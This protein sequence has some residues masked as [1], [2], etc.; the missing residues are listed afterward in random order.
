MN[1]LN[2][3]NPVHGKTITSNIKKGNKSP[4]KRTEPPLYIEEYSEYLKNRN[5]SIST[6]GASITRTKQFNSQ[7]KELFEKDLSSLE[8]LTDLTLEDI[9]IFENFLIK[10]VESKEIK[11]E[12][13]YCCIKS[14]RLFLQFLKYKEIIDFNYSIPKKFMVT[15]TR[16]NTVIPKNITLK[17]CEEILRNSYPFFRYRNL[18]ILLLLVN[19][20]CRPLEISNLNIHDVNITE[21]KI[22]LYSVKSNQRTLNIDNTVILTL[23]KYIKVR[24][25]LNPQTDSFFIKR[26]GQP[27]HPQNITSII[28][29]L[30]KK[31]FGKSVANARAYRHTYI[32]NAIEDNNDFKDISEAVGHKHWFSTQHYL[33]RSNQRLLNNT[34][35]YDP[36]VNLLKEE[37]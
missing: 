27:F 2:F 9:K 34:L 12:T 10:R 35:Q 17:M 3:S 25:T 6:I 30:N 26:N 7:F 36:M 22:T 21:K 16:I 29:A 19:L 31:I 8:G 11:K 23:K 28:F 20:G 32:T 1:K 13:A 15:P 33:H 5:Y 37:E 24:K 4:Q 14:I 18:A